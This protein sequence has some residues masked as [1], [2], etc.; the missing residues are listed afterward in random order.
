MH[1]SS[2]ASWFGDCRTGSPDTVATRT[3]DVTTSDLTGVERILSMLAGRRYSVD[4]FHARRMAGAWRVELA[5][6]GDRASADL[7][8]RRLARIPST[9]EIENPSDEE[10]MT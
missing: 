4:S 9:I 1:V 3:W 2:R 5:V 6:A 8:S 7:L 10:P